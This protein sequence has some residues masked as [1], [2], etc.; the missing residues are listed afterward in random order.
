MIVARAIGVTALD[1][2]AS[3]RSSPGSRPASAGEG[4]I[5]SPVDDEELSWMHR[6]A[7]VVL[8]LPVPPP[9][10]RLGPAVRAPN[11]NHGVELAADPYA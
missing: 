4:A 11:R 3:T 7:L 2:F 8:L 6:A 9:P 10:V 1:L 5:D